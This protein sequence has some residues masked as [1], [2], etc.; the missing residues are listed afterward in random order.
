MERIPEAVDVAS[1]AVKAEQIDGDNLTGKEKMMC[2]F[3][4][5]LVVYRSSGQ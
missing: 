1:T 5:I 2:F 4:V 3:L